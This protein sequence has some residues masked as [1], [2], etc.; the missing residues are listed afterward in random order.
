M[1]LRQRSAQA[2]ALPPTLATSDQPLLTRENGSGSRPHPRRGIRLNR[3]LGRIVPVILLVYVGYAY[4]FVVARY[5]FRHLHLQRQ[6]RW[7]PILWLVPAHGLFLWSLRTYLR[8]F[9]AHDGSRADRRRGILAWLRARLGATFPNPDD[10]QRQDE[11]DVTKALLTLAT[12]SRLSD[13][14]LGHA[15]P[16]ANRS[17]VGETTATAGSKPF[18]HDTAETAASAVSVSTTTA[19]GSTTTSLHQRRSAL[20]SAF[21][22]PYLLCCCSVSDLWCQVHGGRS[23]GY[24]L[25]H[26]MIPD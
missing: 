15:S 18:A 10:A 2:S 22:S 25:S 26:R 8:V 21:S 4:D 19:L 12:D 14:R 1:S 5:A 3:V 20:L 6:R 17:A 7:L 11:K 16:M 24:T 23:S 13:V 9:F